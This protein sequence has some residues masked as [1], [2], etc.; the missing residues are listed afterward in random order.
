LYT[1]VFVLGTALNPQLGATTLGTFA[2]LKARICGDQPSEGTI[3]DELFGIPTTDQEASTISSKV[4]C[5]GNFKYPALQAS[6]AILSH[7][8]CQL[9]RYHF[10]R[11]T[12]KIESMIPGLGTHQGVDLYFIFGDRDV[13]A[14][15]LS[16]AEIAFV[17]KVQEVW[18]EFT[19]AKSPEASFLISKVNYVIPLSAQDRELQLVEEDPK[20]ALVFG[21]DLEIREAAVERM[22]RDEIAFWKR[23][24][25]HAAEQAKLGRGSEVGF[26]FFRPLTC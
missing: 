26:D 17:K 20:E 22:S 11:Q 10:D 7:P 21:Q 16:P 8:I 6:E 25:A 3:F 9:S 5:H 2:K 15:M 23:S 13:S 19:T 12:D 18:I 24:H 4:L 1:F 14:S